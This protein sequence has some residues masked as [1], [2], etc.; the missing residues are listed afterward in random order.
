MMTKIWDE[1]LR[2]VQSWPQEAQEELAQV[3]LEIEAALKD[4]AYRANPGELE[5]IDRG[6]RDSAEGKFASENDVDAIFEKHRRA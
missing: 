2:R 6:L 5:G 3:A 4:G 1:L